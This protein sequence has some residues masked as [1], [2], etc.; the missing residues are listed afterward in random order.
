[1]TLRIAWAGP[2]NRQSAIATFG[3]QVVRRLTELGHAV[4][5][6]RTEVGEP[7]SWPALP[8]PG[9][10]HPS[11]HWTADLLNG[12]FDA[13]LVNFGDYLPYHGAALPLITRVPCISIIHDKSQGWLTNPDIV[14]ELTR[15]SPHVP[16]LA[17]QDSLSLITSLSVGAIVHAAH[18]RPMVERGCKGP[19][20]T[21]P[22]CFDFPE[23]APPRVA[24][25][26]LV[27]VTVG[28]LNQN[29]RADQVIRAI[30]ASPRLR[31][32]VRYV[33]AGKASPEARDELSALAARVGIEPPDILG[34][35]SEDMLGI[36]LAGADVISCLRYPVSEGASASLIVGLLSGRPTL[37]S[38][39]G[40][41]AEVPDGLVLK[42]PPGAEAAHVAHYFE[43]IMDDRDAALAM[44]RRARDHARVTHS[45]EAYVA[46]L[47]TFLEKV[48]SELAVARTCHH[49]HAV[50]RELGLP[51]GPEDLARA[52]R[53]LDS[54][55]SPVQF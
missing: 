18:Y 55:L 23:L 38:D 28:W 35:I 1:M 33:I 31:T 15:S 43:T 8:A 20:A 6:F 26:R 5:V 13:V 53:G 12:A 14:S 19:V 10:V 9:P 16:I 40:C 36:V 30:A 29:K 17:T 39:I 41:Y 32:S 11:M 25:G 21:I 51:D 22:L 42:C 52:T 50:M 54:L 3:S 47:I 7:A 44:G 4:E 37:V 24:P 49:L 34:E 2:W 48:Y 27:V 45:A 46:A